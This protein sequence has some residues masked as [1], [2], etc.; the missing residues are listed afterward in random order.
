M[1]LELD[2]LDRK[3]IDR[4]VDDGRMSNRAIARAIDVTEGAV[5]ARV[6][7]LLEAKVIRMMAVTNLAKLRNPVLAYLWIDVV[8]SSQTEAVADAL[9]ELPEIGYVA[10]MLG[11]SDILAMTLVD[12]GEDLTRFLHETVEKIPGIQRVRYTLGQHFVK[13]DYHYCSVIT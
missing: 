12:G 6:K 4:L 9:S 5:R 8:V 2:E 3:I 13:H 10:V 11:R 1:T 7:R